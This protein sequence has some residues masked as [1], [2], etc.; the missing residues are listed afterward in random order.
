M[1]APHPT[2][3]VKTIGAGCLTTAWTLT[4]FGSDDHRLESALRTWRAR[5]RCA[6]GERDARR[7]GATS[8]LARTPRRA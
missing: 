8:H 3:G 1:T 7:E 5:Y 6:R 2:N 4:A